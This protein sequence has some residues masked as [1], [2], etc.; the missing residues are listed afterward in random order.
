MNLSDNFTLEQLTASSVALRKGISNVPDAD[1]IENLKLLAAT[2][3]Q[4]QF[5]LGSPLSIDSAFRCPKL[6]SAVGGAAT[7]AHLEGYAA[8]FTCISFGEPIVICKVIE[9]SGIHFDQC[10]QEG[11]WVHLSAAPSMR[12][13][14]LTAT[15]VNGKATY[16]QGLT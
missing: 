5:L 2:L 7:S 12:Q 14:V 1:Q 6:N 10:I 16:S 4:V 8:D 9:S 3:E 15:F 11:T 13:Q